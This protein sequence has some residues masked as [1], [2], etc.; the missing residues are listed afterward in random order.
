MRPC[1]PPLFLLLG[2]ALLRTVYALIGH[3]HLAIWQICK[4]IIN[5]S[6]L[7]EWTDTLCIRIQNERRKEQQQ[8][9][10]IKIIDHQESN[11]NISHF[12]AGLFHL[13]IVTQAISNICIYFYVRTFDTANPVP[14]CSCAWSSHCLWLVIYSLV[15]FERW[16]HIRMMS[17]HSVEQQH[18]QRSAKE[19]ERHQ[20]TWESCTYTLRAPLILAS[21][22]QLFH[23]RWILRRATKYAIINKTIKR[24]YAYGSATRRQSCTQNTDSQ[25][26]LTI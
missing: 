15:I 5:L 17:V 18:A 12:T 21:H 13:N 7:P 26:I 23:F 8:K 19:T 20:H 10:T 14:R 11:Y 2:W 22:H 9:N 3:Q 4:C 6:D 24:T 16:T 25:H 1:D